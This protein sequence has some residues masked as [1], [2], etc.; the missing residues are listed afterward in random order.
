MLF[1]IT[2]LLSS[3]TH[4]GSHYATEAGDWTGP[5]VTPAT[6]LPNCTGPEPAESRN[7]LNGTVMLQDDYLDQP[8]CQIVPGSGDWC[9]VVTA[10][11]NHEGGT[12][13][14]MV[15]IVSSDEGATWSAPVVIE[16]PPFELAS[17]Y[18]TLAVARAGRL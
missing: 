6:P 2:A 7:I 3:V 5:A 13:E 9:C 11:G 8:Y 15:S 14:H 1:A 12:G 17:A 18:G 4:E 16:P 10:A